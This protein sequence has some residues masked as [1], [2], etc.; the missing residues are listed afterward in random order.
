MGIHPVPIK[1]TLRLVIHGRVQGVFFRDSMRREAQ[2]LAVAGWVRNRSDGTVEAAV[3]GE[4]AAVDAIV[5]WAHHGPQFAQVDQ[6]EI[7]PDD[8]SY[9]SFEVIE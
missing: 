7:N 1:T 9:T 2:H 4:P 8:G 5:R 6:V 3:Q